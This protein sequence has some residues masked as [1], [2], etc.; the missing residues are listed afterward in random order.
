MTVLSPDYKPAPPG[1]ASDPNRDLGFGTVVTRESRQRLLNRNGS[2]T[3]RREGLSPF[4]SLSPYHT[5]LTVRWG[6]FFVLLAGVYL[7][8]NLVFATLYLACGPGALDYPAQE[9]AAGALLEAFFF[10]VQT[11]AT[12]GYGS[13]HPV[14]VAANLVVTLESLVGILTFALATGL[15]FA[16]FSLP[17]ARLR[18]SE[19]AVVAPY[20][21]V[22]GFMFRLVNARNADLIDVTCELQLFRFE[23]RDGG[24]RERA[25]Y[26]L[27]LERDG[28]TFFSLGWTVVH[29]IT[30]DSP[31]HGWTDDRL[32]ES[33]AE[34]LVL[35]RAVD[36]MLSHQ[37][38]A[39][40]SYT[41]EEVRWAARFR[42]LF[43]PMGP[44]GAISIDIRR[45]DEV[46]V[47]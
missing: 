16:R 23:T 28:V 26:R 38:N 27:P 36:D 47:A 19:H 1:S 37:V 41:A 10:S 30:P 43:N 35:I 31:L 46:E 5:L 17:R 4:E 40:T 3:A 12:I 14:G 2:F 15:M 34:F 32:R 22:T 6:W 18:F 29:P 8:L 39:R 9:A 13:I 24:R 45:L 42:S 20:G 44:D 11:F 7:G 33:Q 25:F 21:G